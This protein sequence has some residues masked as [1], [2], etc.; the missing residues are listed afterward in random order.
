VTTHDEKKWT[1]KCETLARNMR[2]EY[3]LS[4]K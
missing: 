4:D 1:E 2:E 3:G